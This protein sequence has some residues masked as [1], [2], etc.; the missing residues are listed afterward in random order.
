M[1]NGNAVSASIDSIKC[2]LKGRRQAEEKNRRTHRR[3]PG[4]VTEVPIK[5][6]ARKTMVRRNYGNHEQAGREKE[7]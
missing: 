4:K 3:H 7:F 6:N 5:R 2:N 1:K